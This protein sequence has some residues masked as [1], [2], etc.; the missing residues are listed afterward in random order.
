MADVRVLTLKPGSGRPKTAAN[1]D[2]LIGGGLKTS[3]AT[4]SLVAG[5]TVDFGGKTITNVGNIDGRD[6]SADGSALDAHTGA[7]SPHSGHEDTANKDQASGYAG[8][9]GSSK[10]TGS[11]QVYGSTADTAC[12]G[13]DARLSD[14]RECDNTF[15]NAATSRTN[16]DV[17]DKSEV[18]GKVVGLYDHKGAYNANTN[19]PDLDTSPSGVKKGDAYTVSVAG[20]FFTEACEV[21]DVLIA[22]QDDPTLLTHWTRVNK[23]ISFG[24]S[25]GT[26]CEGDDSRLSDDR[27]PTAHNSDHQNGGVDE[28]SVAGLSGELADKQKLEVQKAGAVIGTRPEINF[29]EGNNTTLTVADNAGEGRIDVTIA[30]TS[31]AAG[32]DITVLAGETFTANEV[33]YQSTTDTS[34]SKALAT[35]IGTSRCVGVAIDA[36]TGA[37]TGK[38]RTQGLIDIKFDDEEAT[39]IAGMEVFLSE[40]DAGMATC[41]APSTNG[42]V[43][44]YLG[45]LHDNKAWALSGD[46]MTVAL[47]IDR[48][49]EIED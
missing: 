36:I 9:D 46:L 13:D 26:A 15:T 48:V 3:G 8:L 18:D 12:E 34:C 21:G 6:V 49:I 23:N 2:L 29:I 25:S 28:I 16:L 43:V 32:V 1:A 10:L 39:P 11:Q 37:T 17:Y 20:D 30:A 19:S 45:V 40:T 27:D 7:V 47:D 24:S 42:D 38:L 4:L 22:D 14:A 31:D 44:A 41:V 33:A 5:T 35:A